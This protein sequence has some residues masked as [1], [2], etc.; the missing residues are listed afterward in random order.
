MKLVKILLEE[1]EISE[2]GL[3]VKDLRFGTHIQKGDSLP[4]RDDSSTKIFNQDYI[5]QWIQNTNLTGEEEVILDPNAEAWFDRV[6]IPALTKDSE[7]FT[8]QKAQSL[9]HLGTTV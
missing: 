9:K 2:Q 7:E 8:Q 6:K 4:N 5:D 1:Q 3:K